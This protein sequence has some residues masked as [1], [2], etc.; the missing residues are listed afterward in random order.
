[1]KNGACPSEVRQQE[2]Q[3]HH[4]NQC[5]S[6]LH[7]HGILTRCHDGLELGKSGFQKADSLSSRRGARS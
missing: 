4:G 2:L 1:M 6:K 5:Y 3:P 7:V